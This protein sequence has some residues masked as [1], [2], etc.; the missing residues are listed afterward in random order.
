MVLHISRE[1]L[2]W[3]LANPKSLGPEGVQVS[4]MF[5]ISEMHTVFMKHF[6]VSN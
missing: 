2:Q 4:E 6:V 3:N 1:S 5:W